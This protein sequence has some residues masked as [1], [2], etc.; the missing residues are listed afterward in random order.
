MTGPTKRQDEVAEMRNP[1]GPT[2]EHPEVREDVVLPEYSE[3][4]KLQIA[5]WGRSS[6]STM[7]L[8][9]RE[10][11]LLSALRENQALRE[12]VA[13]L[14]PAWGE[15]E[16]LRQSCVVLQ[17]A[18][19]ELTRE[20]DEASLHAEAMVELMDLTPK[21]VEGLKSLLAE[22][23]TADTELTALRAKLAALEGAGW[24]SVEDRMPGVG[25][26]V[27][28]CDLDGFC[29][30]GFLEDGVF[31]GFGSF[32]TVTHWRPLPSPPTPDKPDAEVSE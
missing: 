18:V 26:C 8:I 20:R 1:D 10:E 22:R 5:R 32:Q 6:A 25:V 15:F 23:N 27:L 16:L 29:D 11:G 3:I 28:C 24:V 31:E 9:E 7:M 14:T 2:V 21:G 30:V 4:T 19:A 12:Q 17:N 13:E